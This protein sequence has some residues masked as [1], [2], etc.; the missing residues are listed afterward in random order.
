MHG[1]TPIRPWTAAGVD[2]PAPKKIKNILTRVGGLCST[3]VLCAVLNEKASVRFRG[4]RSAQRR[5]RPTGRGAARGAHGDDRMGRADGRSLQPRRFGRRHRGA[6]GPDGKLA[7]R[8]IAPQRLEKAESAP[9]NGMASAAL[10]PQYL[11]EGRAATVVPEEFPSPLAG[12]PRRRATRAVRTS[13]R[14]GGKSRFFLLG[15]LV[16]H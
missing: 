12:R 11:V 9:G 13:W 6:A 3:F 14:R 15:L 2:S 10:D 4:S 5:L 8:E 7:R 16:T 1:A